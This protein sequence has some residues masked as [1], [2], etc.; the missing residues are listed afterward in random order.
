MARAGRRVAAEK[1]NATLHQL[2]QLQLQFS[3]SG[4]L[5]AVHSAKDFR[6]S[7]CSDNW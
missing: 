6:I 2:Q 5:K 7:D 3:P 4:E 1:G